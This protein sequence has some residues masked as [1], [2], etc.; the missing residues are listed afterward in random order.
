MYLAMVRAIIHNALGAGA[1]AFFSLG[2]VSSYARYQ[3]AIYHQIHIKMSRRCALGP[4]F[5]INHRRRAL[6]TEWQQC[7]YTHSQG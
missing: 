3:P 2:I 5:A 7:T 6:H 4:T 1:A